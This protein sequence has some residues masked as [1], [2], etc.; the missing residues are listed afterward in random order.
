MAALAGTT[1]ALPLEV[2]M[3]YSTQS[4]NPMDTWQAHKAL[5]RLEATHIT[6]QILAGAPRSG[7]STWQTPNGWPAAGLGVRGLSIWQKR[8]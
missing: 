3:D 2:C 8:L 7:A 4:L 6:A 5:R 1:L